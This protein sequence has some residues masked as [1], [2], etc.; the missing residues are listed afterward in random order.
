MTERVNIT[1]PVLY[2]NGVYE[3]RHS[4]AYVNIVKH[5]VTLLLLLTLGRIST[6]G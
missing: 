2:N 3:P 1:F 5:Y 6:E 4:E